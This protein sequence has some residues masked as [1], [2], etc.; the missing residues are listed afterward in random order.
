M[1]SEEAVD[2]ALRAVAHDLQR[3][4]PG[5]SFSILQSD[6]VPKLVVAGD[7]NHRY[8]LTKDATAATL[9]E[10]IADAWQEWLHDEIG[11]ALPACP[12][13][14]R[15]LH[16]EITRGRAVWVCSAGHEV[17]RIGSLQ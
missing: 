14:D 10:S 11:Q 17:A 15:G 12:V 1:I 8:V 2:E 16:S 9:C 5:V 6:G 7:E 3:Y 13:H 4:T